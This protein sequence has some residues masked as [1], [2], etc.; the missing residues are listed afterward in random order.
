[1]FVGDTN[2]FVI[3][4]R[5]KRDPLYGA[6]RRFLDRL[7]AEGAG[8]TTLFN[9]L[10]RA[11]ILSFNLNDRQVTDLI[12]LF[13]S[14]Y[15]V[16]G[17]PPVDLAGT[18]PRMEIGALMTRVSNRCAFG[19]ALVIEAAERFAPAGSR[20]VTWDAEHFEGRTSLDMAKPDR[21]FRKG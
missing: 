4:L 16:A 21:A 1:M 3:D 10:E 17:L 12:A 6:N 14:R 11:G 2:V 20:F 18:L 7:A 19:D 9:L 8:A 5:Y 13:P 15:R